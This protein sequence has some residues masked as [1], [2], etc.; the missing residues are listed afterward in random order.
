MI[1][2][3]SKG[4]PKTPK[5]L[6]TLDFT[7]YQEEITLFKNYL[8][9]TLNDEDNENIFN[10]EIVSHFLSIEPWKQN[11]FIVY[12][13]NKKSTFTFGQLAELLQVDRKDLMNAI[14]T[15]KNELKGEL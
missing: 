5:E 9:D 12:T 1:F 8:E 11:L 6:Q 7:T 13:L 4:R 10:K 15:I 2:M 3:T 14:K